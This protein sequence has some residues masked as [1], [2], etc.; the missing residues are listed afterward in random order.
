MTDDKQAQDKVTHKLRPCG[1]RH[2]PWGLDENS[3][4]ELLH[5]KAP[6]E[7]GRGGRESGKR[8]QELCP[9]PAWAFTLPP[10]LLMD[11]PFCLRCSQD[12]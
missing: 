11:L 9:L 6:W 3:W 2:R 7:E 12:L 10:D 8:K 4:P 1:H 5:N